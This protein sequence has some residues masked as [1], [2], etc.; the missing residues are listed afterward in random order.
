MNPRPLAGKTVVV[1]RAA[2]QSAS[3][4]SKLEE[5]GA[6]AVSFPVLQIVKVNLDPEAKTLL[7]RLEEFDWLVFTSANGVGCFLQ[8]LDESGKKLTAQKIAAVGPKT[9]S[10]L[11]ESGISI[12][13]IPDKYEGKELARDLMKSVKPGSR[14]LIPKG[15]L[16]KAT[17]TDALQHLAKVTEI[18]VYETRKA[19]PS[20]EMLPGKVDVIIFMSPS[21]VVYFGEAAGDRQQQ[22]HQNTAAAC[23]G[24]VTEEK[25]KEF[26]FHKR[27]SATDYTEEGIIKAV[28]SYFR[29]ETTS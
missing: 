21:S 8:W 27:I 24:P 16:A 26:G 29:E 9:A 5:A 18:T 20:I 7:Q 28:K 2:E 13:L 3:L 10:R 1:T 23:V 12:D 15:N 11:Q 25:A 17:V 14:V 22:Y 19:M 6:E 4:I